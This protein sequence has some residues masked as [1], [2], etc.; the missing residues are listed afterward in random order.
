MA[1]PIA[2]DYGVKVYDVLTGFKFIGEMI[3]DFEE[4]DYYNQYLFGFEE[5]YGY[6]AGTH[7]RD[8]DAVVASMLTCQMAADYKVQGMSLYEGLINLYEKYGYYLERTTTKTL[9][10]I[11]GTEQIKAMMENARENPVTEIDGVK[12]A[13]LWDV[14]KG[15]ITMGDG[16]V[17]ELNLPKSNVLKF[18]FEDNSWFAMRPSGTEPKIKFYFGVCRDTLEGANKAL[19]AFSEKIFKMM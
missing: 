15:T 13:E 18:I 17:K 6:L 3:K 4:N 9:A 2:A 14:S 19:D 7:A 5:S 16:T 10:G 11:D 1:Y 12:V 8:K